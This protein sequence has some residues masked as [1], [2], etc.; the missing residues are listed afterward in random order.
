[1]ELNK[2]YLVAF[3]VSLFVILLAI[4]LYFPARKYDQSIKKHSYLTNLLLFIFNNVVV[5][6]FQVSAVTALAYTYRLNTLFD[7]FPV[8]LQI[9]SGILLLDLFVW[10]WHLVNHKV[11]FLW[12]FHKCHHSEK[13]L[14]VSSAIRFHLGELLLS[15]IAKSLFLILIGVP[16]WIFVLYEFLITIFAAFHHSNILLPKKVHC[17]VEKIIITPSLHRTHHSAL[18]VEHDTNY[19]VIFSWWDRLFGTRAV[20]QPEEIGLN[21]TSEKSFVGFIKFPFTK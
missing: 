14:N 10:G 11:N 7:L 3:T 19:G 2:L 9:T 18:R 4:E 8:W 20:L 5:F 12:N 17:V 21:D 1:M 6:L 13:Y 16:F 15:V